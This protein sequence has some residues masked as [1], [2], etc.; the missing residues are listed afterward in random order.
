M[1]PYIL[2]TETHSATNPIP[3]EVAYL[4]V[5][6]GLVQ[7]P[8]TTLRY[9]P[10]QPITHGA[11]AVHHI[12]DADVQSAP[13]WPPQAHPVP[14]DAEYLI[15]HNIDFD[16]VALGRPPIH[17][18]CTLALARALWPT[19]DSHTQGALIYRLE[20]PDV[21][22]A[23][24]KGAHGAAADIAMTFVLLTHILREIPDIKGWKALHAYCEQARIPT[25][26]S[27][28]KHKGQPIATVPRDYKNWLLKQPDLDPY[29]E[30]ALTR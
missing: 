4:P 29:M 18:I 30:K 8:T 21:A 1:T 5:L 19:A 22:R 15:G 26:F 3:I 23:L 6:P 20:P 13:A 25:I 10:G 27:F 17:R 28:G 7:G 14:E 24:T 16:W 9:N 2:D 12:T 11:M